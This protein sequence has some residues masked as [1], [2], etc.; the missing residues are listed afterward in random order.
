MHIKVQLIRLCYLFIWWC[1]TTEGFIDS[2]FG[3]KVSNG[4][5]SVA[6][7]LVI[8]ILLGAV[9]PLIIFHWQH[10]SYISN[11]AFSIFDKYFSFNESNGQT[12]NK[13]DV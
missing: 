5:F 11:R 3:F 8:L 4:F 1:E 7:G 12:S 13:D 2:H 10:L 6:M 9:L